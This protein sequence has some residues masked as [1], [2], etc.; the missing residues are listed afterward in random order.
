MSEVTASL[1]GIDILGLDETPRKI[2]DLCLHQL[3]VPR[4]G[5]LHESHIK[6]HQLQAG[7]HFIA[8]GHDVTSDLL[9]SDDNLL[10]A[11]QVKPVIIAE[12]K[13]II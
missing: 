7:A 3:D 6:A 1:E 2:P 11:V 12:H 13:I 4:D 10:D 5:I 9:E 8:Q